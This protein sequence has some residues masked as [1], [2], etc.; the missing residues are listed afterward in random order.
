MQRHVVGVDGR[1]YSTTGSHKPKEPEIVQ[2]LKSLKE[3]FNLDFNKIEEELRRLKEQDENVSK[4][5]QSAKELQAKVSTTLQRDRSPPPLLRKQQQAPSPAPSPAP[6]LLLP[7]PQQNLQQR[8]QRAQ[9][10]RSAAPPSGEKSL[11]ERGSEKAGASIPNSS[12]ETELA[13]QATSSQKTQRSA[14]S[15][16]K[17]RYNVRLP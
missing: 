4:K 1:K 15:I 16:L 14:P 3:R 5:M 12:R 10:Q 7:Q 9:T 6:L 13:V 8:S 11:R 2:E 17:T